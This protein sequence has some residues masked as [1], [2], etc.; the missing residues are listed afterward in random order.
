MPVYTRPDNE[1]DYF[2]EY[3]AEE[4]DP[5]AET[6]G[7]GMEGAWK[8]KV[9]H[10]TQPAV[11]TGTGVYTF[12]GAM[13]GMTRPQV[14]MAMERQGLTPDM[15]T[16]QIITG[17][18]SFSRERAG[19]HVM[20][21][22]YGEVS[23]YTAHSS[24]GAEHVVLASGHHYD[25]ISEVKPDE[26]PSGNR[27]APWEVLLHAPGTVITPEGNVATGAMTEGKAAKAQRLTMQQYQVYYEGPGIGKPQYST[28]TAEAATVPEYVQRAEAFISFSPTAPEGSGWRDP[29]Q[30]KRPYTYINK[31]FEYPEGAE[32]QIKQ[33]QVFQRSEEVSP[34]KGH[35][36]LPVPGHYS[37][38]EVAHVGE[39]FRPRAPDEGAG[40]IESKGQRRLNVQFRAPIPSGVLTSGKMPGI[41]TGLVTHPGTQEA[42][43][44]PFFFGGVR[45]IYGL[46]ST[47]A[48]A[49][50]PEEKTTIWG[51]PFEKYNY[52]RAEQFRDWLLEPGRIGLHWAQA[53]SLY[54]E[55]PLTQQKEE[56]GMLR[57]VSPLEAQGI[58]STQFGMRGRGP[59]GPPAAVRRGAATR[60]APAGTFWGKE[61]S[62]GLRTPVG[63][64]SFMAWEWQKQQ[65]G[66]ETSELIRRQHPALVSYYRKAGQQAQQGAIGLGRAYLAQQGISYPSVD[67]ADIP[68]A[69]RIMLREKAGERVQEEF[70]F[71][72]GS[73]MYQRVYPQAFMA[74]L[75]EQYKEIGRASCR[76]RVLS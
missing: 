6:S 71:A 19:G 70:G 40:G 5:F 13:L 60:E 69:Q 1:P 42:W 34:Y 27:A 48:S 74:A 31:Q 65:E 25:Y 52:E 17:L 10:P 56:A 53:P 20:S 7:S 22:W 51:E 41:K 55:N 75:G 61:A 8:Y 28:V 15:P 67:V 57:R 18:A 76:E 39:Y 29:V 36:G 58:Q 11:G 73:K 35:P 49:M 72:P 50:T 26:Y 66:L 33:G 2:E 16:A 47:M 30:I 37:E 21:P 62:V 44:A 14:D 32:L 38:W 9:P 59:A 54:R 12:A 46:G 63:V 64:Q 24:T 23:P 43:G 3:G 45:D 4:Q 68:E